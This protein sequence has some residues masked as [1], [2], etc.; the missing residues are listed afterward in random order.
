MTR[1]E[2]ENYSKMK[3]ELYQMKDILNELIS[4]RLDSSTSKMTGTSN[5]STNNDVIG[6]KLEKIE[7]IEDIYIIKYN[8]F[9]RVH[10][11][12]EMIL[13]KLTPIESYIIRKRYMGNKKIKWSMIAKEMNYNERYILKIHNRALTKILKSEKGEQ[14]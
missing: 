13:N 7:K 12:I 9:I 1:E 3:Y 14:A 5:V 6:R 2:L 11:E 8:R 10:E 4:L